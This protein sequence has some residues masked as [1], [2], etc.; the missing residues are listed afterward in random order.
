MNLTE[1]YDDGSPVYTRGDVVVRAPQGY[2]STGL[3]PRPHPDQVREVAVEIHNLTQAI[4][5]AEHKRAGAQ[6][7]L[8]AHNEALDA[9]E[10]ELAIQGERAELAALDAEAEM[11]ADAFPAQREQRRAELR[12]RLDLEPSRRAT[13]LQALI[14]QQDGIIRD[15]QG[16]LQFERERQA[17]LER[18][19][20]AHVEAEV[21]AAAQRY[22]WGV[23]TEGDMKLLA[24]AGVDV[25]QIPR[26]RQPSR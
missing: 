1:L 7:N 11:M 12:Q 4:R 21:K 19:E 5:A 23:A 9:R 3:P 17:R 18:A 26:R 20:Q 6:L 2:D 24:Q 10:E 25:R 16:R 22:H 15:G 13:V 8:A 14:G